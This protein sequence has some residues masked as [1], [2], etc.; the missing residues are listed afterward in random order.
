MQKLPLSA[1]ICAILALLVSCTTTSRPDRLDLSNS[2]RA[3]VDQAVDLVNPTIVRIKVVEPSYSDGRARKFVGF[4]SGTIIDKEG[5][6]MT[7]HHVAGKAVQ[8][9]VTMPNR[10]EL[11]AKLVGTDAA[12][13]IAV[14]KLQ[15]KEEGR[16][17]PSTEFGNSDDVRV[18]DMVLAMG[19]PGAISQSVTLG[20]V[21]NTAIIP[22]ETWGDRQF[23]LDGENVGRLVRWIGHD[24]AIYP[25]NSGGPL[26]SLDGKIIGV[27][28]IGLG[29]GGAIPGNLAKDVAEEI[30]DR[31][32]VRRAYAGLQLQ[33]LLKKDREASGVLIA[34]VYDDS[35]AER[36]GLKPGQIIT[37]INGQPVEG[38]FGEDLPDIYNLISNL[39]IGGGVAVDILA[40]D[41]NGERAAQTITLVPEERQSALVPQEVLRHW[42]ITA[43]DVTLWKRLDLG[44]DKPGGV[45][46]TSTGPGGPAAQAKPEIKSDDIIL[47]VNGHEIKTL[48]ELTAM[49]EGLMSGGDDGFVPAL[50]RF[51][52]DAEEYL[53]VVELGIEDLPPPGRE[54]RKAW[55]PMETQPITREL[56]ENL[57]DEDLEGV[58]ITRLYEERPEDFPLQVGDMITH[59]DGEPL[60]ISAT[61]DSG[62]FRTLIRQY[63]ISAKVEFHILRNMEE[64]TVAATLLESPKKAREVRRS[65]NL[66]FEFIVREATFDD[67][68]EPELEG[69]DVDVL[70]DSVTRGGWADLAG[71]NSG[72]VVLEI[73]GREI[74]TL[75]DVQDALADARERQDEQV[76]VFI[77]RGTA[78]KYLE[79]E[80]SWE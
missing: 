5:H 14:I 39:P 51:E 29:L 28:E 75:A 26:I 57:G 50:V 71:L 80:P 66:D 32:H 60:D 23:Q 43:R 31:G 16:E 56:A 68:S 40:R 72:D 44:R 1:L 19:S 52:R 13:D 4:G 35:P 70:V 34:T 53:T 24:A 30:I 2:Q 6:I 63:P 79:M 36:A 3:A 20:I 76:I 21:S 15:P 55:L 18:G 49:T 8:L 10:E 59:V 27:N 9:V 46:V 41:G 64:E 48:G 62:V 58:R 45:V 54:V 65:R 74:D 33:P 73:N 11:P 69:V 37:A 67:R 17:F 78:N 7:N 25:G 12:T 77:R 61:E 42:G 38:R 22:P 47:S